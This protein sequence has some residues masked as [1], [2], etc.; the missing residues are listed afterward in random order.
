MQLTFNIKALV[1]HLLI[2]I[3]SFIVLH[4]LFSTERMKQWTD[5]TY[6]ATH[7]VMYQKVFPKLWL[8][9]NPKNDGVENW[10]TFGFEFCNLAERNRIIAEAKK[11]R[12][13]SVDIPGEN[14]SFK[15]NVVIIP[16]YLFLI[17]LILATPLA[18]K[19]KIFSMILGL[20]LLFVYQFWRVYI[21]FARI[22]NDKQIGVYDREG[23]REW[24]LIQT[25]DLVMHVGFTVLMTLVIWGFVVFSKRNIDYMKKVMLNERALKELS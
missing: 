20:L 9:L 10:N 19:S 1:K 6:C 16:F 12:Q 7:Q 17:A 13:K 8:N 14:I 3:M 25:A 4:L 11:N 23:V 24:L 22:V 21:M 2:F 18:W 15:L 5:E